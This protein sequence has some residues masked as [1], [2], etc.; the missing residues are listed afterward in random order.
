MT[1]FTDMM[2]NGYTEKEILAVPVESEPDRKCRRMLTIVTKIVDA[3][4]LQKMID[5]LA[6][7]KLAT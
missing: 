4:R 2:K 1:F 6:F 3:H 7:E 5:L